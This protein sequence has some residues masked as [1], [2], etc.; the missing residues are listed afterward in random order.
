M[1]IG[2]PTVVLVIAAALTACGSTEEPSSTGL[3]KATIRVAELRIVDAAPLHLAIDNGHFRAEGL[4]VELSTGGRGSAN[5]DNVIGGSVDVGLSSYPPAILPVAKHVAD[6][7]VVTEAVTATENLY[8]L[9][10]KKD[11][12]VTDVGQLAGRKIAISS[13]GGIGELAIRSQLA[14]AGVNITKDQYLSMPFADMPPALDRGD[15]DAAIMN[16]PFVTQAMRSGGVRKLLSPFTGHTA[17][18]P[19]SGW[20]AT[21]EFVERNPKTVAAFQRAMAKATADARQRNAVEAAV[22]K[23]VQ[24]PQDIAAQ[25][26]LPVYPDRTD[27]GRLQRVVDLMVETGELR[28]DQKIDMRTMALE[29]R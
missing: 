1:R 16:E 14:R 29:G 7:R 9:V 5:I 2:L 19:T 25:M 22:V 18:F 21:K 4:A 26:T 17:G 12:P 13:Q 27:A 28:Q 11:G 20:I 15:V 10:V 24:V 6:L 8:L 23:Y 3:E